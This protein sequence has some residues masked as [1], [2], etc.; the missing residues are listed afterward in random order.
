V[1]YHANLSSIAGVYANQPMF[2]QA[3]WIKKVS[4]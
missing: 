4:S 2:Y 3:K 1:N